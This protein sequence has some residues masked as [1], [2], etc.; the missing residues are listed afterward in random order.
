[1][2]YCEQAKK[3]FNKFYIRHFC[4]Y[5]NQF[6]KIIILTDFVIVDHILSHLAI[7]ANFSLQSKIIV[8]NKHLLLR[9]S[10][11]F[12]S[13][14]VPA[15]QGANTQGSWAAKQPLGEAPKSIKI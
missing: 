2:K 4:W 13:Y 12:N 15:V 11:I 10:S 9:I 7:R 14:E 6:F 1:M 8:S 3:I 5:C